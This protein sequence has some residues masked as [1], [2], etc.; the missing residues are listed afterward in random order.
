MDF[1][2]REPV[3][4]LFG[5]MPH[6]SL[7]LELEVAPEYLGQEV[8]AIGLPWQWQSY[9][10]FDLGAQPGVGGDA[11]CAAAP[12]TLA[13][14][15]GGGPLC[16][17]YSGFAGVSNLGSNA[18]WT[19]HV[20]SAANTF[21]FGRLAWAP[22]SPADAV[23]AEWAAATFPGSDAGAVEGVVALLAA[24]WPAYENV[25]ASL[26]WG[27][28]C[29]SNHFD[30]DPA[31][32][33]DYT[34]AT[35]TRIGYARGAPGAYAACYNGAAAAAFQSLAACPE[36]LLLAFH[37]VP[38]NYSLAGAR[39]GGLTVLEWIYASHAAGAAT[40]GGFVD[41]WRALAG[42]L[43]MSAYVTLDVP[44]EVDAFAQVEA[45]LLAGAAS[46]AS[47]SAAV[48]AYFRALVR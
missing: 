3:H 7:L 44:S 2:V 43:N 24:T 36:E 10:E 48:S 13:G 38:Y 20:L 19:G 32:R 34:N 22:S 41:A 46:A 35:S 28:V 40:S 42:R 25:T 17:P 26:G 31:H 27:F 29:A 15:A 21:G 37:N 12:T 16:S 39:Y 23:V 1:Q 14:V 9:L 8:H 4:A 30:M 11:P 45:R 18:N 47:F 5:R 6:T 33:Q